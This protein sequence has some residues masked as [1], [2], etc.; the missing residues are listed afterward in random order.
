[1][2]FIFH[3]SNLCLHACDSVRARRGVSAPTGQLPA[4]L[5]RGMTYRSRKKHELLNSFPAFLAV[6][7]SRFDFSCGHADPSEGAEKQHR[8][9]RYAQGDSTTRQLRKA[10]TLP[11]NSSP[12][13]ITGDKE[14]RSELARIAAQVEP[15]PRISIKPWGASCGGLQGPCKSPALLRN[16]KRPRIS[17]EP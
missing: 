12:I 2:C 11:L 7:I 14:T 10:P 8:F 6:I 15:D 5:I 17:P 16:E 3:G 9:G 13:T 4:Q 1:M